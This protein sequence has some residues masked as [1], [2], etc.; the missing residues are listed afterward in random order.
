MIGAGLAVYAAALLLRAH[1]D[2]PAFRQQAVPNDY[3]T[4]CMIS[5]VSW[6]I[7]SF[8]LVYGADAFKQAK[9]GLL[10]LLL[11]IPLPMFML[12][13]A[14]ALLQ[15]ASAET[16]DWIF[17]LTGA[18]YHRYG[19]IFEFSNVTIQVA[20]V[21]SGIRSTLS[22]F[23]LGIITGHLFLHNNRN[24][25]LL[26][27]SVFPITILK[28]ALRIV[29]VTLLANHV[30]M[31]FLTDHWIHRSGGMLFIVVAALMLVPIVWGLRRSEAAK[32]ICAAVVDGPTK[33]R[34][35]QRPSLLPPY[36]Q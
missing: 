1:L 11:A 6:V 30:D 2:G 21:C 3:L 18:I 24:R 19:I 27:L 5:G 4:L 32:V 8:L 17:R 14:V 20:E 31:E 12:N 29:T 23:I 15:Q 28:N 9:F 36:S 35:P 7:G 26:A 10:F 22:L 16:A 13:P 34:L 25:L 33:E